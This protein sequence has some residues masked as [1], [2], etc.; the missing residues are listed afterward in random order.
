MFKIF[1]IFTL[2]AFT[3]ATAAELSLQ[4]ADQLIDK[5]IEKAEEMGINISVAIVDQHGNLKA[6]KRM[7]HS[8]LVS[9]ES[10][11]M[12]AFTSA[13]T[14]FS[15]KVMAEVSKNLPALADMPGFL[16]LKGGLPI[17]TSGEF[18]GAIGIGGA[19]GEQDELCAQVA[20]DAVFSEN[21]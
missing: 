20:L 4:K 10:A 15:T 5:A 17:K 19:A 8:T 12:K 3:V 1:S 16:L 2:C 18:L 14:S 9:A 6:F 11:R 21:S 13:S 7:D